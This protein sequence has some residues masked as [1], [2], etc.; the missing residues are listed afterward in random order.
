MALNLL[1]FIQE[2][3]KLMADRKVTLNPQHHEKLS[4]FRAWV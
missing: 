3:F 1:V 2:T 4:K